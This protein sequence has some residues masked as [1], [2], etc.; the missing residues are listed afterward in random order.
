[1]KN[2]LKSRHALYLCFRGES[3]FLKKPQIRFRQKN[4]LLNRKCIATIFLSCSVISRPLNM[5]HY[6]HIIVLLP[7]F[8]SDKELLRTVKVHSRLER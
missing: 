4:R 6:F 1:M 2:E 7:L 3:I 8:V 5:S